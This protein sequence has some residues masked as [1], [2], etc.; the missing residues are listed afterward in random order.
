MINKNE[1]YYAKILLF[2]EY[3]VIYDSKGLSVPYSHFKGELDFINKNRYTDLTFANESNRMLVEFATYIDKLI[4]DGKLLCDFNIDEF[5]KDIERGLFFESS[6]PQGFGLGSSGALVAAV[7]DRYASEKITNLRRI[8]KKQIL[9][10]KN[11]FSQLESFFHG[12][13]SGI[14]PLNSYIKMPL[15]INA[16]SDIKIVGLP[17]KKKFGDGAIF[18]INTGKPRKTG[19]L[20]NYFIDKVKNEIAFA[21]EVKNTMIPLTDNCINSLVQGDI[22]EFF[23]HLKELSRF[24]LKYMERMIPEPFKGLWQKGI[25]TASYYLKLCGSGGGGFILGFS[26]NFEQAKKDLEAQNYEV[27][28]VFQSYRS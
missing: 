28:P 9:K 17:R 14:D 18:L 21:R 12:T 5:K 19:P 22:D 3:S 10:L 7:Y 23:A 27:I 4:E 20:V 6:I 25:E 24:Q 1:L 8:G 15:L 2:G 16:K 13:S 11:I 26:A